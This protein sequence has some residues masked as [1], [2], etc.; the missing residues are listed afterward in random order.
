MNIRQL[1][2]KK[3][4]QG[5]KNELVNNPALANEG[6]VYDDTPNCSKAHPLHRICDGVFAGILTDDEAFAIAQLFL[7]HG[8]HVNGNELVVKHDTPLIAAASL[9]ADKVAMLY[10]DNGA[11]ID[12]P[13]CH[14]GTALHWA[15]WCGR[16][17]LVKRLIAAGAPINQLCIDFKST[18][19]FWTIHGLKSSD[20]NNVTNYTECARLL[21]A[22]GADKTIPNAEG[23][24]VFDL[25]NEKDS[26]LKSILNNESI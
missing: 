8:A 26:E 22:A 9:N 18:P 25:L 2:I 10:I 13:G 5:I 12:H 15:A 20:N 16:D 19:L 14:G 1:I 3:D 23:S 6:I 7:D 17:A 4:L 21:L 11:I 24:T